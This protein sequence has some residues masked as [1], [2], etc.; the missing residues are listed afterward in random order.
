MNLLEF[1]G[2]RTRRR[3][4]CGWPWAC[5]LAGSEHVAGRNGTVNQ[6]TVIGQ[7]LA[8]LGVV[9]E[10]TRRQ[11]ASLSP[12]RPTRFASRLLSLGAADERGLV[13]GLSA[14][15][16]VPGVALSETVLDLEAARLVP[17]KIAEEACFLPLSTD[18][19]H[20]YIAMANP[21]DTQLIDELAF[22][23]GLKVVP[24]VAL[25]SVLRA[26][27][28]RAYDALEAGQTTLAG[29][30]VPEDAA[31]TPH[32]AATSDADGDDEVILFSTAEQEDDLIAIP[33]EVEEDEPFAVEVESAAQEV[34][35]TA[36][37]VEEGSGSH[38]ILV[39][40]DEEEIRSLLSTALVKAGYRVE[41]ASRGLEAL[42]KVK[43]F[44]PELLVLDA[45]L[46][47]VHGFEICRKV[48]RSKRFGH[49]PVVMISAVYRGWR[50]AQ[51]VKEVYGA[52]DFIEKPFRLVDVL[53]RVRNALAGATE[54]AAPEEARQRAARMQKEGVEHLRA[55]RVKE[56]LECFRAGL[57]DDPFSPALHF[58]EGRALQIKG[59]VYGAIAAYE[60]AV[61]LKPDLF[62]ALKS[63]GTLYEQKGFRRKAIES[64]ERALPVAPNDEAR[65]QARETL[66][67]LI[68]GRRAGVAAG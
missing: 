43:S 56:A 3:G 26:S 51:D 53:E 55:G 52:T 49:V 67:S 61:E 29:D 59:D 19:T 23:T 24:H 64:W 66:L 2:Y 6:G 27:I 17:R 65:R 4:R 39:V 21:D 42:H 40:D 54:P 31:G 25:E 30:A 9:D 16:G 18:G 62:P 13:R 1:E 34:A 44:E 60:R 46:P 50:Y 37:V 14:Q 45:M 68:E 36:E 22:V 10:A 57:A 33:I 41:T 15:K 48:R 58:G 47:E 35:G 8:D 28:E 12:A 7:I 11:A 38:R 20:L 32:V 5:V 63:L